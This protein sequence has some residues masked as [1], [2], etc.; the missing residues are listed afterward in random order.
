[1]KAVRTC[2][3]GSQRTLPRLGSSDFSSAW[4]IGLPTSRARPVSTAERT[5]GDEAS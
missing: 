1:M 3:E 2:M 4:E 5:A